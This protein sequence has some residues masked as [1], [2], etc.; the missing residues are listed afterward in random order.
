[1]SRWSA[2]RHVVHT[3]TPAPRH[4]PGHAVT[5][6]PGSLGIVIR[7]P[8]TATPRP[9]TS[10]AS[11]R[12]ALDAPD[13]PAGAPAQRRQ[14]AQPRRADV[15]GRRRWYAQV[16]TATA[17]SGE[18]RHARRLAMIADPENPATCRPARLVAPA[19]RIPRGSSARPRPRRRRGNLGRP[20]RSSAAAAGGCGVLAL[21]PP[22]AWFAASP[23]LARDPAAALASAA[24]ASARCSAR[25]RDTSLARIAAFGVSFMAGTASSSAQCRTSGQ[26]G[27]Q[28][29]AGRRPVFQQ[30]RV[31]SG[32][33]LLELYI[34]Q[35]AFLKDATTN[36]VTVASLLL[37]RVR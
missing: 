10:P 11:A 20:A 37:F 2:A 14:R 15:P 29:Q 32:E 6:D 1:M 9:T 18:P 4:A 27:R 22:R 5:G 16:F 17:F 26:Q 3:T 33:L 13:G 19:G 12:P 35:C 30:L 24:S 21:S 8:P 34:L 36:A 25:G 28:R 23:V 31:R 7:G